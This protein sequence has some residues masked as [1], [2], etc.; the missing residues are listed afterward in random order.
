MD[1]VDEQHIPVVEIGEDRG[2][3][4][5]TL[6]KLGIDKVRVEGHT[7]N[8]GSHRYND[9]LAWRRAASVARE[10]V[11][12]GLGERGIERLGYG[13]TK[14]V[15]DNGTPAGRAQNR[16]VVITVLAE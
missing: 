6:G 9:R 4:A 12:A 13:A 8:V 2:E 5:R 1:L 14:P 15:A 16:R 11:R 10:L 7:D 3:V